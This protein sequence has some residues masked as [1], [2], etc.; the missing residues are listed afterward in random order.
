MYHWYQVIHKFLLREICILLQHGCKS[1]KHNR[2]LI[3]LRDKIIFIY[4]VT[5]QIRKEMFSRNNTRLQ[6]WSQHY[7]HYYY[8]YYQEVITCCIEETSVW[9]PASASTPAGKAADGAKSRPLLDLTPASSTWLLK[10]TPA[11]S[12][13]L[14]W[15]QTLQTA[16]TENEKPG[17]PEFSK[18]NKLAPYGT[19]GR[20]FATDVC[21]QV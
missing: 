6:L 1:L 14:Y 18:Q 19:D 12:L 10:H 5:S 3:T 15:Q 17:N 16:F 7:Y 13:I 20:L 2:T 11:C 9:T 8:H 4:P 21:C